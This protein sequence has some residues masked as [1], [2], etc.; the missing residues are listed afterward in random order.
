VNRYYHISTVSAKRYLTIAIVFELFLVGAYLIVGFLLESNRILRFLVN[1]DG[2]V[3]IP[4]FF[5]VAQLLMVGIVFLTIN[6]LVKEYYLYRSSLFFT[7]GAAF[8]FMS[9]DEAIFLHESVSILLRHFEW[10]PTVNGWHGAWV[11]PYSIIMVGII[12]YFFKEFQE[13]QKKHRRAFLIIATGFFIFL[14][15]ALVL[16][17]SADYLIFFVKTDK[18]RRLI[19]TACEEFLEMS[20]IS[21]IF[22][23]AVLLRKGI[24]QRIRFL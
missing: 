21:I 15:G 3:N 14:L 11:F 23:G 24:Q 6:Q 18:T 1:L 12:I 5:S 2:E 7:L 8:I 13:I 20:G 19:G 9:I 22:Y 16:E 17:T 4:A 10:V